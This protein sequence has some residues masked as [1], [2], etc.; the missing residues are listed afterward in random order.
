[1]K[2]KKESGGRV[3]ALR[4]WSVKKAENGKFFISPTAYFQDKPKWQGPYASMQYATT[5]IARK[6]AE[7][8]NERE[9][10]LLR[11]ARR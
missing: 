8:F 6:L 10:R 5:A 2:A 11:V 9:K 4:A 7:E 3:L 1:M